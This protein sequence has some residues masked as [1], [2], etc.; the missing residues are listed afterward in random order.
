[1]TWVRVQKQGHVL[2]QVKAWQSFTW[3]KHGF[4][5]TL[6]GNLL[7]KQN[8]M[9]LSKAFDFPETW[10]TVSQ[11]HGDIVHW[12]DET[13]SGDSGV[14]EG[15]GL[16]TR[17]GGQTLATFYADCVPLFFVDPV[18]QTVAV[19]HG[20]WRGTS[21]HIGPKT[22]AAMVENGSRLEDI[23]AAIGPSI[24]PCCYA[25][26]SELEEFFPAEVFLVRSGQLYLDLWKENRR[27][28]EDAGVEAIFTAEHCTMCEHD[29]FSYRRDKTPSRMAAVIAVLT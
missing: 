18:T 17:K 9:A 2:W 23:Q 26:S 4:S 11:V 24:G 15:D 8:R 16:I 7:D 25:V 5:T 19:S 3:L 20:G 29:F 12:V 10:V 14:I 6:A 1:M 28:L 22:I 27:Q 21:K 13:W